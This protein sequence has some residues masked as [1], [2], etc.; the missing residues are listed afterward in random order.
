VIPR[1]LV[2]AASAWLS[3]PAAAA[4]V[5]LSVVLCF[6]VLLGLAF[7]PTEVRKLSPPQHVSVTHFLPPQDDRPSVTLFWSIPESGQ[8]GWQHHLAIENPGTPPNIQCLDSP[9]VH[10]LSIASGPD[11][12]HVLI[13]NWNGTIFSLDLHK[14]SA[15]PNF[16]GRQSDGGVVT[17]ACSHD[18][19]SLIS[20]SAFQLY[21]WD[22]AGQKL[23]WHRGDILTSCFAIRPDVATAIVG[24]MNGELI[25]VNL[26]DGHTTGLLASLPATVNAASLSS[27]GSRLAVILANGNLH[28]FDGYTLA[29]LWDL[30]TGWHTASGHFVAF[31]PSGDLLVTTDPQDCRVL[32]VWDVTAQVRL[33]RLAAHKRVILGAAFAADGTLRSWGADGTIRTWNLPAGE[34]TTVAALAPP[35]KTSG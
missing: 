8:P 29:P 13:G 14:P 6:T 34:P 16:I 21:G 15:T 19:K 17:L 3:R 23:R 26:A 24:C 2:S 30:A 4:I 22:L 31:S 33:K 9:V 32:A 28:L 20:K 35:L 18:G 11:P 5:S 1:A 12:N 10:P 25:E 27:D 7:L